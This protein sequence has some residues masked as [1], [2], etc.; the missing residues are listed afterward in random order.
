VGRSLQRRSDGDDTGLLADVRD[1]WADNPWI[2]Y[3]ITAVVMVVYI[4]VTVLAKHGDW[5]RWIGVDQQLAV[6]GAGATVISILGGFSAIA[7]SVYLASS[8]ERARAVRARF[9]DVLHR[10]WRA[11]IIGLGISAVGCLVAL[12]ID[13]TH[14]PLS[15]R[16]VFLAALVFAVMRFSRMVWLF[17]A[18]MRVT[19]RDLTDIPPVKPPD[20]GQLW[21]KRTG[22]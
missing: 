6:Y 12:I 20:L 13:S 14:D 22:T 16:F 15:S 4:L 8:G 1:L 18:L 5:L 9:G 7:V 11:I 3:A 21:Q 17:D 10:N 19:D 2:D